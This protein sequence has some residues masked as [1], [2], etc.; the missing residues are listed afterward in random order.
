[1][2]ISLAHEKK[3][4]MG[5]HPQKIFF[6]LGTIAKIIFYGLKNICNSFELLPKMSIFFVKR[7]TIGYW[8][9]RLTPFLL[10]ISLK[11]A[12][13]QYGNTLTTQ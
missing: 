5:V 11:A 4:S 1:M 8:K 12:C 10:E 13:M 2:R 3:F 9:S 6:R 7:P